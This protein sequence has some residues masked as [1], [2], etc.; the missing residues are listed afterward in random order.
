MVKY[1]GIYHRIS[2]TFMCSSTGVAFYYADCGRQGKRNRLFSGY[3]KFW[4]LWCNPGA[5]DQSADGWKTAFPNS[6]SGTGCIVF[7]VESGIWQSGREDTCNEYLFNTAGNRKKYI[8][9]GSKGYT[10]WSTCTS[11]Q[12]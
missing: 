8:L 9:S 3:F 11:V 2:G 6:Y 12:K 1:T 5:T 4:T 10:A 7:H